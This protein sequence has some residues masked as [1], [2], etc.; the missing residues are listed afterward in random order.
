M[1]DFPAKPDPGAPAPGRSFTKLHAKFALLVLLAALPFAAALFLALL[2]NAGAVSTLRAHGPWLL[3]VS[4]AAAV[5]IWWL[6]RDLHARV[7]EPQQATR[8][9]AAGDSDHRVPGAAYAPGGPA[10]AADFYLMAEQIE[11]R[12]GE[13]ARSVLQSRRLVDMAVDWHW[14]TDALQRVTAITGRAAPDPARVLGKCPWDDARLR[15]LS[16]TWQTHRALL[17]RREPF[18]DL[19]LECRR[20]DGALQFVEINGEPLLDTAGLLLGYHGTGRDVTRL[21][22]AENQAVRNEARFRG[23]I[24]GAPEAIV[25][26]D[27]HTGVVVEANSAAAQLFG[28][29]RAQLIGT[30]AVD[31]GNSDGRSRQEVSAAITQIARRVL[32]GELVVTDWLIRT[33]DG[34]DVAVETRW[35][36]LPGEGKLLRAALVDVSERRRVEAERERLRVESADRLERLRESEARFRQLTM[37]SSD[38]YWEQDA[39][40]RFVRTD[41][42]GYRGDKPLGESAGM[43][44][45]ERPGTRPIGTTWEAH[46]ADLEAHRPFAHLVLELLPEDGVRRYVA[47]R[48]EPIFDGA[49][50]FTGY[51]GVGA[52]ISERYR[53]D[54]V[55]GGERGLY[56]LLAADAS[57]KEL[58][59]VL[60]RTVDCALARPGITSLLLLENGVLRPLATPAAPAAYAAML[61][62]G[63]VPGPR[64][65]AC[66]T[67]AYREAVVV[68][69]DIASDPL[70]DDY[71]ELAQTCGFASGWSTPVLGAAGQVL[72]TFAV[73]CAR[74][75]EPLAADIELTRAAAALAGV[76]IER[77][78]AQAAERETEARYKSLVEMSR[79]AVLIHDEQIVVYANAAAARML[80][81]HDANAVIGCNL[82]ERLE[83]DSAGAGVRRRRRALDADGDGAYTEMRLTRFDDSIADVEVASAPVDF[84]GRR[85]VQTS[86]HDIS[87]R[88]WAE[89]EMRRLNEALEQTVAERTAELTAAVHELEAFS[90]T[91]AHDLRAPL[92][93]IDG[94]A[95]LLRLES[96]VA[97]GSSAWRDLDMIVASARRMGELIDGLLE[98]SRLGRGETAYQRIATAALVAAVIAEAR[99]AYTHQP[100]VEIR[101][102]PD[103]F[104][105]PAML[106]QVWVNLIFNAFKFSARADAPR[107]VIDCVAGAG[108]VDFSVADNGAGFDGDYAEKLFGMFQR[109][110]SR[111]EFEGTG[112]GL[113]IVKR[114]IERHHGRVWA[115]G[116]PGRGAGFHFTLPATSMAITGSA[117]APPPGSAGVQEQAGVPA[118]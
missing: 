86:V 15:P 118:P 102:L 78:R 51:R 37:L 95:H 69:A 106:R 32:A 20:E 96:G 66:G 74:R 41:I 16:T 27:F 62:G 68:C 43:T 2:L 50:G 67:T 13:L 25:V 97:S 88:K 58:M 109:L 83:T 45:W 22:Q 76:L 105:D 61:Q 47:V 104:G 10:L 115:T 21:M 55:R 100:Q 84:A 99:N 71:R 39:Q 7:R 19:L 17:G 11:A 46:R 4:T 94:Y 49:G 29:T 80:A 112:V 42:R 28:C 90:Y 101:T 52:D 89:R 103:V 18:R 36:R 57:L 9:L 87:A 75:A 108:E 72:A 14:T 12:R 98:F 1:Q 5:G 33:M 3:L 8:A 59:T 110:H 77:F 64:A 65:G 113:A 82:H 23:L 63:V 26:A 70:W 56:E 81:A 53:S 73:Y 24:E 111:S 60:C 117:P 38:W 91:V 48:G 114:V 35:M 30:A 107:I 92:R 6:S 85:M 34:R 54:L 31:L 40:Y 116:A 79:E 93:A 44:R